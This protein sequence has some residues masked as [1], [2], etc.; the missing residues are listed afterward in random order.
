MFSNTSKDHPVKCYSIKQLLQQTLLSGDLR[1]YKFE[2]EGGD[3]NSNSLKFNSP[4][5][6]KWVAPQ[7]RDSAGRI[8]AMQER[9]KNVQRAY[10]QAKVKISLTLAGLS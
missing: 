10:A 7:T 5:V 6:N 1:N 4:E 8:A 9:Q 3:I 2:L